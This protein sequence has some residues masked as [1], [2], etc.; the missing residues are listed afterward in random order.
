M[1]A[2]PNTAIERCSLSTSNS[3]AQACLDY[4]CL[5]RCQDSAGLAL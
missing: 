3:W 1:N 4:A 5:A 2:A